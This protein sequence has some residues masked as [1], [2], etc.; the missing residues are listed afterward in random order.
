MRRWSWI[1]TLPFMLIAVVFAVNN[2]GPVAL[3]LW[4][5][6]IQVAVP[7]YILVLGT[8]FVGFVVGGVATWLAAGGRRRVARAENKKVRQLERQVSTLKQGAQANGPA[9]AASGAARLTA[10][11]R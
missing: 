1:I 8:L 5:L 11:G 6:A 10:P 3:D 2:M 7:L 9:E 4:P